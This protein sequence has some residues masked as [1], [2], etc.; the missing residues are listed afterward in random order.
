[1]VRRQK[2][3]A[4]IYFFSITY[5]ISR[6]L[7]INEAFDWYLYCS[8]ELGV[9]QAQGLSIDVLDTAVLNC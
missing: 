2:N 9:L 7:V 6:V 3:K 4:T 8:W 1:M 5:E